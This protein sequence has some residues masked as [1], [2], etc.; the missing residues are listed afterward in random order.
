MNMIRN[1]A[2]GY[3]GTAMVRKNSGEVRKQPGTEFRGE[4]WAPFLRAEHEMDKNPGMGL[5]HTDL[6]HANGLGKEQRNLFVESWP[7]CSLI[8]RVRGAWA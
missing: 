7:K 5:R 3:R 8:M 1:T 6:I 4:Q 2:H